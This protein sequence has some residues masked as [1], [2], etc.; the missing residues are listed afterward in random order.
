MTIFPAPPVKG[1]NIEKA[2]E[3]VHAAH[4]QL[5][6]PVDFFHAVVLTSVGNVVLTKLFPELAKAPPIRLVL[7]AFMLSITLWLLWRLTQVLNAF[8]YWTVCKRIPE[9]WHEQSWV[10]NS[11]RLAA[12]SCV[13]LIQYIVY[14]EAKSVLF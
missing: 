13:G 10:T 7:F 8:A 11:V 9:S 3:A 6:L 5:K 4:R 1:I 12:I 14:S 2:L